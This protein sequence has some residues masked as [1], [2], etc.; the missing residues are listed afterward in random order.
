M[1][2]PNPFRPTKIEH[3]K[4]PVFLL[5]STAREIPSNFKHVHVSGSRGSGKTT[6]LRS[7]RTAEIR[8]NHTL[9]AQ[10]GRATFD[11]FGVYLQFAKSLQSIMSASTDALLVYMTEK[12]SSIPVDHDHVRFRVFQCYLEISILLAFISDL[13]QVTDRNDVY[14]MSKVEQQ[15]CIELLDRL[16]IDSNEADIF[17]VRRALDRA[18]AHFSALPNEQSLGALSTLLNAFAP[19]DLLGFAAE[20]ANGLRGQLVRK[21]V[22]IRLMVLIDDAEMLTAD[23]QC[24]LNTLLKQ[25]EGQIK[26]VIA[27]IAGLYDANSTML[28]NTVL[29]NDDFS[30]VKLDDEPRQDFINFCERVTDLR[31]RYFYQLADPNAARPIPPFTLRG[32]LGD[33]TP[34]QL[35]GHAIIGSQSVQV[36]RWRS[37]VEATRSQLRAIISRRNWPKF[38]IGE[39]QVPFVEHELV[40]LLNV[41][42]AHLGDPGRQDSIAKTF[43]RKQVAALVYIATRILPT[44]NIPYAGADTVCAL[45]T[46]CIRDYLDI[47]A[48]IYDAAI[49]HVDDA[50]KVSGLPRIDHLTYFAKPPRPIDPGVQRSGIQ[51]ASNKKWEI[52]ETFTIR[53]SFN[54]PV[55]VAGLA[56]LTSQ[57]QKPESPRDF[58][59]Q[60]D[61]GL[62]TFDPV[63]LDA[64][65][66]TR[67]AEIS[68]DEVIAA[69]Q[70]DGFI[71]VLVSRTKSAAGT[72]PRSL[73]EFHLHR[74]LFPRLGISYRGPY[75]RFRL[76]ES[77]FATLIVGK[78]VEPAKWAT[79]ALKSRAGPAGEQQDFTL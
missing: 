53:T 26:F 79:Q 32:T 22:P 75:E 61:R 49:R 73:E 63:L 12:N 60:A 31:L 78:S 25:T 47:M 33:F 52:L 74:R 23:Q 57:L 51:L 64:I 8:N 21:D 29:K 6:L 11:W 40:R 37:Q 17:L 28:A 36:Q 10:Y 41:D 27:F 69:L 42:I 55:V 2:P 18:R 16:G 48:E 3:D 70:R 50:W 45:A 77:H 56:E 76:N 44:H 15:V 59:T 72:T 58:V 34:N 62:F 20:V 24:I 67:H 46:G 9:R 13:L 68:S 35:I 5:S 7:L 30:T 66:E 39:N 71:K 19:G 1:L 4:D 38:S 14:I 54:L 43:D 65:L